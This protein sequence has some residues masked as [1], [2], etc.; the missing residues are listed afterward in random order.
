MSTEIL[1]TTSELFQKHFPNVYG[2]AGVGI[3]HPNMEAFFTELN[4]VCKKEDE[5]NSQ[6]QIGI[7]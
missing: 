2:G 6:K 1:P 7:S 5:L 4:E 3:F